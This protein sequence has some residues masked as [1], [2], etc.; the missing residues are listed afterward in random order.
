MDQVDQEDK[1]NQVDSYG[2]PVAPPVQ[3]ELSEPI[4]KKVAKRECSEQPTEKC[5]LVP[6]EIETSV[7]REV[8]DEKSEPICRTVT[9]FKQ[10]IKC[11]PDKVKVCRPITKS[12]EKKVQQK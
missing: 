3:P 4:C 8:C 11:K 2:A 7:T 12:V 5:S 1:V 6:K 10:S 9:T